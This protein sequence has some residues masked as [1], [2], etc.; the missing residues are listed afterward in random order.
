MKD[1]NQA[2]ILLSQPAWKEPMHGNLSAL[3][4]DTLLVLLGLFGV[5]QCTVSAFSIPVKPIFLSICIALFAFL[6][7]A[8]FSLKRWRMPILLILSAAYC[9]TAYLLRTY[10]LQGFLHQSSSLY[11]QRQLPL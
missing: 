11:N 2:G 3:L 5:A 10:F 6:F 1:G 8:I 7:L 9:V 4:A